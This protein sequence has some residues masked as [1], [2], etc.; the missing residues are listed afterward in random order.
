MN[1]N[2]YTNALFALSLWREA[3]DEGELGMRAVGHVI[4]NRHNK[5]RSLIRVITDDAQFTSIN[6]PGKS[7]DPQ[8]DEWPRP[9]D[10]RFDIAMRIVDEIMAGESEDPTH[11][12]TFYRN[13]KTATSQWYER[14]VA[15]NP[16]YRVRAVIGNHEFH[17]LVQP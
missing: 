7:Y 9:P 14:H 10:P 13:P 17:A 8:L 11:G 5:G 4:W 6:P 16:A 15:R 12:A 3:R 1:W 2:T